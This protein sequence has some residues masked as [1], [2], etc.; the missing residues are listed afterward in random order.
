[1]ST[2]YPA[3]RPSQDRASTLAV[4]A[5]SA[6]KSLTRARPGPRRA[7]S[8]AHGV[9]RVDRAR[10]RPPC[11]LQRAWIA[12]RNPSER[13]PGEGAGSFGVPFMAPSMPIVA[14]ADPGFFTGPW[15][16]KDV[17]RSRTARPA[18]APNGAGQRPNERAFRRQG[19]PILSGAVGRPP[20]RGQSMQ[21][22]YEGEPRFVVVQEADVD[23]QEG[24]AGA[25]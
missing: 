2:A 4:A 16:T 18:W 11:R 7:P 14:V 24:R 23:L 20:Q 17:S 10:E 19:R 6:P 12:A 21:A 5:P 8:I 13:A 1:M 9:L 15:L 3:A 22:G 25:R